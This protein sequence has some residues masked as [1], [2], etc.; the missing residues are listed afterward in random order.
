MKKYPFLKILI[1]D[2]D[3]TNQMIVQKKLNSIGIR[4]E[5]VSNGVEAIKALKSHDFD[6]VLMD[7]NMPETDGLDAVR[8]IREEQD[9]YS[10]T[11]PIFALTSYD[12]KAH[13]VEIK[14]AGMNEHLP[15]PLDLAAL[16]KL[17]EKYFWHKVE[18]IK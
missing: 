13:T 14:E 3:E 8:W 10:R 7:I 12:T 2:D 1:V 17:I 4:H 15:K 11:V 5:T 16:E 6:F 9:E 18:K